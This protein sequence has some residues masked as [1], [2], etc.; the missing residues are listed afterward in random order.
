MSKRKKNILLGLTAL[1]V[2]CFLYVFFRENT[3]VGNIFDRIQEVEMVREF[4]W[5]QQCKF[6]KFYLPDF[7]WGFS[8][9]CGLVAINNSNR[10]GTIICAVIT[11][12]CGC[13]WELLQY[14]S[15]LSGT[16]DVYDIA[17]YFLASIMCIIFNLK[18]SRE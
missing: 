13:L 12:L 10:K 18:E 9:S 17:M 14:F 16:G 11:F 5:L 2:G 1:I 15:V 3:Y 4:I 6:C 8:L 7:L